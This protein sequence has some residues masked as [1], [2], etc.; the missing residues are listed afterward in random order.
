MWNTTDDDGDKGEGGGWLFDGDDYVHFQ[1][2][3]G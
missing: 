1:S 2:I 3:C